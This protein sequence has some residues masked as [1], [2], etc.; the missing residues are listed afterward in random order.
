[1]ALC[2][3]RLENYIRTHWRDKAAV[4][5]YC[6]PLDGGEDFFYRDRVMP[7]ASN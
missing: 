4:S 7:S 6:R 2:E 5:V 1:M 3:E